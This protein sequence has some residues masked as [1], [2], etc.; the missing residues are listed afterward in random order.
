MSGGVHILIKDSKKIGV[1]ADLATWA[2]FHWGPHGAN[3]IMDE[4][5]HCSIT[6]NTLRV[7]SLY[8]FLHGEADKTSGK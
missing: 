1:D 8:F 5:A 6:A 3:T 4:L 2:F 7:K